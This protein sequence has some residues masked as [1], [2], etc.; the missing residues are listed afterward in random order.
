MTRD[1]K[2]SFRVWGEWFG[3]G[4]GRE[5]EVPIVDGN[6]CFGNTGSR[7][8]A[9]VSAIREMCVNFFDA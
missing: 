1:W 9:S 3:G 7:D 5:W 8:R 4:L 2:G 6:C